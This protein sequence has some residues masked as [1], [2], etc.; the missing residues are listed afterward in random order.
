MPGE[1][2]PDHHGAGRRLDRLGPVGPVFDLGRHRRPTPLV[3]ARHEGNGTVRGRIVGDHVVEVGAVGLRRRGVAGEVPVVAVQRRSAQPRPLHPAI[4]Q[5]QDAVGPDQVL[6]QTQ[7]GRI[8]QQLFEDPVLP[9][10]HPDDLVAVLPGQAVVAQP[11]EATLD[12]IDD[13]GLHLGVELGRPHFFRGHDRVAEHVQLGDVLQQT[14]LSQLPIELR[15]RGA[16]GP[17]LDL[18]TGVPPPRLGR[19]LQPGCIFPQGAT[20]SRREMTTGQWPTA[21][22]LAA[23]RHS[24]GD[25][26]DRIPRPGRPPPY[27][28]A[29]VGCSR[30]FSAPSVRRWR[31]P[32]PA[33]RPR[34]G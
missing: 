15:L 20:M 11:T 22:A 4:E 8:E 27:R 34:R 7:A 33:V 31:C 23:F 26:P 29:A 6:D 32:P 5:R 28:R 3:A 1:I 2:A 9:E 17:V 19:I 16:R 14:E 10:D 18:H 24:S 30:R 25:A 12:H 21:P 13:R